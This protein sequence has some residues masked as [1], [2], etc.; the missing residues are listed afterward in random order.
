MKGEHFLRNSSD[1]R[2]EAA[3]RNL[4]FAIYHQ[5]IMDGKPKSGEEGVTYIE[6]AIFKAYGVHRA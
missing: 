2:K 5:W 6:H 1:N 4:L 3:V